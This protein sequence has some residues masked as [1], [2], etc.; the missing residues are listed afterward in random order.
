MDFSISISASPHQ[1][2]TPAI[3]VGVFTD[4]VLSV[5]ADAIDRASSG[6]IRA[7]IKAEF[8]GRAGSTLVLRNLDGVAAPRIVL[9]GL[10]KQAE[11]TPRVH[12]RAEQA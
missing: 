6:A 10:G 2:K 12:A 11:Y 3:A 7:V 5:A 4:G 1:T 8:T 9:V